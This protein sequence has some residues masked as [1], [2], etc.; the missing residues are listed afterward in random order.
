MCLARVQSCMCLNLFSS[1]PQPSEGQCYCCPHF[2]DE[3]TEAQERLIVAP[4]P[5]LVSG[6]A[7]IPGVVRLAPFCRLLPVRRT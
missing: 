6:G 2:W 7:R 4:G 1:L 5:Q 3:E